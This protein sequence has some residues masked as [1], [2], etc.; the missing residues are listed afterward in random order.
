[1]TD[2]RP[3]ISGGRG[4]AAPSAAFAPPVQIATLSLATAAVAP[5]SPDGG[6]P[7]RGTVAE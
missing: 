4:R 1:M 7:R 3:T 6:R 2:T 5:P